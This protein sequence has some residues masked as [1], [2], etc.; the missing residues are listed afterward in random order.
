MEPTKEPSKTMLYVSNLPFDTTDEQFKDLF[1]GLQIS[2]AYIAKRKNGKSKGFGFVNFSQESEQKK[3]L[4]R[5]N[6]KE[7]ESRKL[8][9]K[10]AFI[11]SRRNESGEL[12]EE[13]KTQQSTSSETVVYVNNLEWSI[14][15]EDLKNH[16]AKFNPK[17][18]TVAFRKNGKS[19]GF[20]FVELSSK[21]DQQNALKLDQSEFKAR[22]ITVRPSTN[23]RDN[24]N[25]GTQRRNTRQSS[26]RRRDH[27]GSRRNERRPRNYNNNNNNN[28][29]NERRRSPRERRERSEYT[30]FVTNLPFELDDNDLLQVFNEFHVKKSHIAS[31]NGKSKGFGFV[32]FANQ[33]DRDDAMKALD[34][35][36]INERTVSIKVSTPQRNRSGSRRNRSDSRR[37][38]SD[39]RRTTR[40]GS[41]TRGNNRS[42]SRRNNNNRPRFENRNERRNNTPQVESK[43]AVHV[44]NL[45][46]TIDDKELGEIFKGMNVTKSNVVKRIGGKSKGFGFV[47]FKTTE[48]Q[49]RALK[50]DGNE[51]KG[52]PIKVQASFD[53]NNQ[54]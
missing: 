53:R 1:K 17:S 33:K 52:R 28:N 7:L 8:I 9:L 35:S 43:T 6:G 51:I 3:A 44:S 49:Q 27:S 14:T 5:L 37:N 10:A 24:R 30:L 40:R 32:E 42:G 47:E 34:Q 48:D 36:E 26:S 46:F 13:F 31:R 29:N 54:N 2:T 25:E 11:D 18:A 38:R 22:N 41:R 23:F 19:K 50:L 12:K 39:S 45:E 20:G 4:E 16:F 15:N 21:E